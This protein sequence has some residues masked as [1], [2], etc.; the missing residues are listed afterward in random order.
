MLAEGATAGERHHRQSENILDATSSSVQSMRCK[1]QRASTRFGCTHVATLPLHLYNSGMCFHSEGR[2]NR[3]GRIPDFQNA[4]AAQLGPHQPALPHQSRSAR[5]VQNT[6]KKRR[7][8]GELLEA[9][10]ASE[11]SV[12]GFARARNILYIPTE[13]ERKDPSS[14]GPQAH[15]TDTQLQRHKGTISAGERRYLGQNTLNRCRSVLQD[16]TSTGPL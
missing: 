6:A 13:T 16:S 4:L 7:L 14:S 11:R 5:R 8:N 10:S 2:K 1:H 9:R 12:S 15:T 3:P